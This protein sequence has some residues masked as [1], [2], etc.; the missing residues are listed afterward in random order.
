MVTKPPDRDDRLILP[1]DDIAVPGGDPGEGVGTGIAVPDEDHLMT[2]QARQATPAA[3][4][5][6]SLPMRA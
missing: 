1:C 6:S 4:I 3:I 5:S 2:I